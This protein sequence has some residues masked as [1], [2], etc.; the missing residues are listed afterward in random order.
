MWALCTCIATRRS[1]LHKHHSTILLI[2]E[3]QR[4]ATGVNARRPEGSKEADFDA[5]PTQFQGIMKRLFPVLIS[6]ACTAE[7]VARQLF[8]PL[9]MSL[10]HG[11]TRSA[12]RYSLLLL[13]FK[14]GRQTAC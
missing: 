12:R 14:I 5:P 9:I 8:Q 6:L 2:C 4:D 3:H 13:V 10:V 11:L 1:Q 7:P